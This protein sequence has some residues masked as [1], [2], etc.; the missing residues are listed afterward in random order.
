MCGGLARS[1][2]PHARQTIVRSTRNYTSRSHVKIS[3]FCRDREI[4]LVGSSRTRCDRKFRGKAVIGVHGRVVDNVHFQLKTTRDCLLFLRLG[5]EAIGSTREE[6]RVDALPFYSVSANGGG[7]PY[8]VLRLKPRKIAK[9][10]GNGK[11]VC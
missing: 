11:D 4:C 1:F 5:V 6:K 3:F 2:P 8:S 10:R 7:S 9:A